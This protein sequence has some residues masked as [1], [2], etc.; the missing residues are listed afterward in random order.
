MQNMIGLPLDNSLK[1]ALNTLKF[2]LDNKVTDSW[3]SIFQPYPKTQLA[4]YAI[5][6]GFVSGEVVEKCAES[7]Y[8]ESRLNIP[9]KDKINRLQKWWYFII[10]HNIP[11]EVAEVL[12]SLPLSSEQASKLQDIRFNYSKKKLYAI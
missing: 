4:N 1:D 6:K 9:N 7:Y 5:E 8:D 2:N 3:V 11:I 10:E 12:I